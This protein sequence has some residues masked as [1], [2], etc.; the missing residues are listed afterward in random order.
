MDGL[1]AR[2][3]LLIIGITSLVRK[4]LFSTYLYCKGNND[5]MMESLRSGADLRRL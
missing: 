3:R 5:F 2:W 4:K 1:Y